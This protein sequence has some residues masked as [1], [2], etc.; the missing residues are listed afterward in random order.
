MYLP[1]KP[2]KPVKR[3]R[4]YHEATISDM[5]G[6]DLLDQLL[7]LKDRGVA[8]YSIEICSSIDSYEVTLEWAEEES[9]EEF[10]QREIA[11]VNNLRVYENA[12]RENFKK[13]QKIVEEFE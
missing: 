3:D 5:D 1:H 6:Q 9:E 11:Y 13:L 12:C 8:L 7:K 10:A 4:K 2:E